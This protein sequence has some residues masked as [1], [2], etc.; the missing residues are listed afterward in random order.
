VLLACGCGCVCGGAGESTIK[1]GPSDWRAVFGA[2][3]SHH[4]DR[5]CAHVKAGAIM[6]VEYYVRD[7]PCTFRACQ[8]SRRC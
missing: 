6:F 5:R 3:G 4:G 1:I 8:A 2:L 7:V